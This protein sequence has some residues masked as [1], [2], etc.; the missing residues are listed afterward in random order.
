M[1]I[2]LCLHWIRIK[3]DVADVAFFRSSKKEVA[4]FRT[5]P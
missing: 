2:G 4:F 3:S 5:K 1:K